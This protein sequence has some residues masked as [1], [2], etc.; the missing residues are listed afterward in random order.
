M[1]RGSG[2]REVLQ[3]IIENA[4]GPMSTQRKRGSLEAVQLG[5]A[6]AFL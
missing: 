1:R 4:E 2:V 5:E 3:E 6:V